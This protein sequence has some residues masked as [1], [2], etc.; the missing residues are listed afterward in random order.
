VELDE[1]QFIVNGFWISPIKNVAF[2]DKLA[3]KKLNNLGGSY[4]NIKTM[5]HFLKFHSNHS[6]NISKKKKH[7]CP[8]F[9]SPI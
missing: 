7:R 3:L 9:Y 4:E 1:L 8:C 5:N 2:V 6:R